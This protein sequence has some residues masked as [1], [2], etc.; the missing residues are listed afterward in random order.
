MFLV[1][2]RNTG[3]KRLKRISYWLIKSIRNHS[4][5]NNSKN[6]KINKNNQI[7]KI[8]KKIVKINQKRNRSFT[9]KGDI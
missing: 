5:N 6:K 4:K 3:R 2:A 7:I 8:N 9:N 1:L